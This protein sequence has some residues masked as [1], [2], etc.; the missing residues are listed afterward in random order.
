MLIAR[1]S[2]VSME[3]EASTEDATPQEGLE[4]G[5]DPCLYPQRWIEMNSTGWLTT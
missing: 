4:I 5:K 2:S 1:E 3:R